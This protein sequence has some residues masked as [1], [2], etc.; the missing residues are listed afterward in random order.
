METQSPKIVYYQDD[1]FIL[2][3]EQYEGQMLLHCNVSNWT[4]SSLR[5]GY[6]VFASL[7]HEAE[8]LG[9]DRLLTVTPNPKFARLFG[10]SVISEL[11]YNDIKHE[12]I[13][14]DLKHQRLSPLHQQ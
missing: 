3:V 13:I 9:F 10:G 8:S 11:D 2:E 4:P 6:R 5:R 1:D 14:W 7:M 12:V